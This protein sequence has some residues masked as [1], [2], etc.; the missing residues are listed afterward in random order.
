M[1]SSDSR[2]ALI[3]VALLQSSLACNDAA[4]GRLW[5]ADLGAYAGASSGGAQPALTTLLPNASGGSGSVASGGVKTSATQHPAGGA[6]GG[7]SATAPT[8]TMTT[9]G[10]VTN[11]GGV[12]TNA[13]PSS[14]G[15]ATGGTVATTTVV[16]AGVS[17]GGGAGSAGAASAGA[18]SAGTSGAAG[19]GAVT[20][21][22]VCP[23]GIKVHP[24]DGVCSTIPLPGDVD[25]NGVI[26]INDALELGQLVDHVQAR[27]LYEPAGDLN[28]D[29][30]LTD[31]DATLIAAI[32]VGSFVAHP[33]APG[34]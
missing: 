29:G 8:S 28:C 22:G 23:I 33:C 7:A 13:T 27:V 18:A 32:T 31:D 12:T 17:G 4:V 16:T 25:C 2:I 15:F 20:V 10:G 34:Q 1:N 9:S 24:S 6:K 3:G 21:A 5:G 30:C 26:D 14:M 11:S 19:S